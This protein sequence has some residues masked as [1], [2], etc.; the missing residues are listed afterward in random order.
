MKRQVK[1]SVGR[2]VGHSVSESV[3]EISAAS[4]T[5]TPSSS[6]QG[7]LDLFPAVAPFVAYSLGRRL[8]VNYS[9]PLIRVRRSSDNAEQ[10][11]RYV[12][13]VSAVL[14]TTAL[15]DFA[16]AGDAFVVTAYDQSGNARHWAQATAD[17]QPQIVATGAVS[18]MGTNLRP[19][20][21]HSSADR[22]VS[23]SIST[24][25]GHVTVFAT[26]R[27]T[28]DP[29]YEVPLI[30]GNVFAESNVWHIELFDQSIAWR[31]RRVADAAPLIWTS[32]TA[33]VSPFDFTLVG[34]AHTA[35]G[36]R[37]LSVNGRGTLSSTGGSFTATASVF[38]ESV[39]RVGTD[40]AGANAFTGKTGEV[41]AFSA[42]VS[43]TD[44]A[45]NIMTFWGIT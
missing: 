20:M 5:T 33:T 25:S 14:D 31:P 8:T 10:D 16:G 38:Q 44:I 35:T 29:A 18:T 24:G 23:P 26:M 15:L 19:C 27:K 28:S 9:G 34:I 42:S 7:L 13:S 41:I 3:G 37:Q 2:S 32:A 22:L 1:T 21:Q 12:D 11:I 36:H 43:S 4:A 40:A 45:A 30:Y 6:F 17:N 39:M